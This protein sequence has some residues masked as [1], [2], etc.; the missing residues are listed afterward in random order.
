MTNSIIARLKG[1]VGQTFGT[2]REVRTIEAQFARY[3]S[4]M[5]H[6]TASHRARHQMLAWH[7]ATKQAE[8]MKADALDEIAVTSKASIEIEN[9]KTT[10]NKSGSVAATNLPFTNGVSQKREF[11][12]TSFWLKSKIA[13]I[14]RVSSDVTM[15][16]DTTFATSSL[17]THTTS[18]SG[19]TPKSKKSSTTARPYSSKPKPT[20][21]QQHLTDEEHR[22]Q[23][24]LI[25]ANNLMNQDEGMNP[26]EDKEG[27][28]IHP[29]S[30]HH[31]H[32]HNRHQKKHASAGL[33]SASAS[34]VP[35]EC[36]AGKPLASAANP[37]AGVGASR[38]YATKAKPKAMKEGVDNLKGPMINEKKP[39]KSTSSTTSGSASVAATNPGE[40]PAGTPAASAAH[41]GGGVGATRAYATS[42]KGKKKTVGEAILESKGDFTNLAN[43]KKLTEDKKTSASVAASKPGESP[44]GNPAASA[45]HPGGGVG[46]S[47][48]Y[49]TTA[50]SAKAKRQE[51]ERHAPEIVS[52]E[53]QFLNTNE[54]KETHEYPP[55]EQRGLNPLPAKKGVKAGREEAGEDRLRKAE[56]LN[57]DHPDSLAASGGGVKVVGSPN[58]HHHAGHHKKPPTST[59]AVKRRNFSTSTWTVA[60]R[61]YATT[62]KGLPE[63]NN[64]KSS[65]ED[66]GNARGREETKIVDK[67]AESP[68]R[69]HH[70]GQHKKPHYSTSTGAVMSRNYVTSTKLK[71]Q[72]PKEHIDEM[73]DERLMDRNEIKVESNEYT[74][75]GTD[76]EVASDPEAY[77][78]EH[79]HPEDELKEEEERNKKVMHYAL[80]QF[81]I[82]EMLARAD[83]AREDAEFPI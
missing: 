14:G 32:N 22:L 26:N 59:A 57:G 69:V 2:L 34:P 29:V 78:R 72:A 70:K 15:S 24:S 62:P 54:I 47:R 55:L 60:T 45:S 37:G 49:S 21:E 66:L 71:K 25:K 17:S 80:M 76:N 10:L 35:G 58:H 61:A 11:S 19:S 81:F 39:A 74:R 56:G 31:N 63:K 13:K 53:G 64:M 43:T 52:S 79:L 42:A 36:P 50:K 38:S 16:T 5:G 20:P 27:M 3:V 30:T 51:A 33:G 6:Y 73:R 18:G 44:A 77:C 8:E 23:E 9:M 1:A 46:A 65:I 68:N 83:D 75:S 40:S 7:A 67:G 12:T 28:R 41:V 82:D 48:A 4:A